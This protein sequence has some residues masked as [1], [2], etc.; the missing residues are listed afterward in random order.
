MECF[1]VAQLKIF[2]VHKTRKQSMIFLYKI[3]SSEWSPF[4]LKPTGKSVRYLFVH[5]TVL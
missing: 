3:E 4:V 5:S 2:K 1:V